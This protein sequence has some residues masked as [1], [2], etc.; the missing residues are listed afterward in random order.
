MNR[1]SPTA[2]LSVSAP[3]ILNNG[4]SK[5]YAIDIFA[6]AGGMS[7]GA[8][9]SG[10]PVTAAVEVDQ[11]SAETYATNHSRTT[12]L[13]EDVKSLT[14][15]SIR[16]LR[17]R[18][19]GPLVLFGGLPC[20]GFSYSN[21]RHRNKDN[22]T[23]WLFRDFLNIVHLLKPEWVIIENVRGIGDTAKGYFLN[24][25]ISRLK[26]ES[27][28]VTHGPLNAAHY[29]VPQNRTRYFIVA[30]RTQRNYRFPTPTPRPRITVRDAIRDLPE[31]PNGNTDSERPYGGSLP[32]DYATTMRSDRTTC[33]NNLVTRNNPLVVERYRHIP[34]GSNWMVLPTRLMSN[35]RDPS[36]CHTGI[37]HRLRYDRPAV[38]IGNYRKNMLIH[39]RQHRGL[40]VREAARLQS[41]PDGYEFV[42]SIGFQ[43]QQVANAVPPLLARAVFTSITEAE[44]GVL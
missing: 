15:C 4:P 6:G 44:S 2:K 10:I 5:L 28:R 40:S 27:F 43:Q 11:H 39:P 29:G 31:L 16:A 34:Q 26:A 30:N 25:I 3:P 7:Q 35:Y 20:Q 36:R 12:L 9:M 24:Q 42:G 32:S 19:Q 41:F 17:H 1:P 14:P 13:A 18:A 23:N 8:V 21:P 37:Y 38:V 33:L 22:D